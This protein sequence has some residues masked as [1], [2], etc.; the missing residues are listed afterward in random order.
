M[1]GKSL[2]LVAPGE[3]FKK[4]PDSKVVYVK[5]HYIKKSKTFSCSVADDMNREVFIKANKI[6]FTN[7]EY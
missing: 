1:N 6:V 3:F 2:N 7:F 4:K 5:N